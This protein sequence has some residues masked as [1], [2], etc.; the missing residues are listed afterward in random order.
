MRV[1]AHTHTHTHTHTRTHSSVK[2]ATPYTKTTLGHI[3]YISIPK[4]YSSNAKGSLRMKKHPIFSSPLLLA[5][6][7]SLSLMFARVSQC[8]AA[9]SRPLQVVKHFILI[10]FGPGFLT[11]PREPRSQ[12][13][14]NCK[15]FGEECWFLGLSC[16]G[17]RGKEGACV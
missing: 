14:Y 4:A 1:R 7:C 2:N 13:S 10:N 15:W 3:L 16:R 11:V 17:V 5:C 9:S 6:V 12:L 8:Y